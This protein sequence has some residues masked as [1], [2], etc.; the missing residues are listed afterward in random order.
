MLIP[1]A[2]L[3]EIM[4]VRPLGAALRSSKT[5]ILAKTAD[6]ELIRL[7]LPARK[8]LPTHKAPGEVAVQW[9]KGRVNAFVQYGM[10]YF[11][12]FFVGL[13]EVC[14]AIFFLAVLFSETDFVTGIVAKCWATFAAS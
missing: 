6:L 5:T 3:G 2:N 9:L 10:N 14:V 12:D 7:V 8:E 4:D 1:H 11:A 13:F